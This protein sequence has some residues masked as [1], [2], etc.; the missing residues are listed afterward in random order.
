MEEAFRLASD[1]LKNLTPDERR[2]AAEILAWKKS[3]KGSEIAALLKRVRQETNR[4]LTPLDNYQLDAVQKVQY[5]SV[6]YEKDYPDIVSTETIVTKHF[7][8]VIIEYKEI[9]GQVDERT[10]SVLCSVCKTLN[11]HTP[12]CAKRDIVYNKIISREGILFNIS[13]PMTTNGKTLQK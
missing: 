13:S 10:V 12:D 2:L 1:Y 11:G 3:I 8:G 7:D 6:I 4:G 9:N 5:S